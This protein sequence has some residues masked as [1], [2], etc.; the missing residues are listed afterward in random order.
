MKREQCTATT[1]GGAPCHAVARPGSRWC[2]FHDP[3]AAEERR[4]YSRKGGAARS[5]RAR[6]RKALPVEAM[7][8][9]EVQ[10]TLGKVLKDVVGGK[11]E[12]G[13]A[14]AAASV[15]RA[16]VAVAQASDLEERIR[17]IEAERTGSR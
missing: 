6:A 15:A 1:S 16:L 12:P 7:T 5:N 13:V 3:N 8:L 9:S 10:G 2:L 4:A 14:S 11:I 17:R